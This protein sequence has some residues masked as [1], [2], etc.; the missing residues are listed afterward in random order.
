M[1]VSKQR[2]LAVTPRPTRR[3][4]RRISELVKLQIG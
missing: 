2:I 3:I 4:K 1:I